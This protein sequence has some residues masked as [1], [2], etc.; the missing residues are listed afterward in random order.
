MN[1][2]FFVIGL[3][4]KKTDLDHRSRFAFNHEECVGT[5]KSHAGQYFILSTCNR[6][7]VYGFAN[8]TNELKRLFQEKAKFIADELYTKV[9]DDAVAHFFKVAAGLDSQIPGDYEIIAQIKAAF[10]LAKAQGRVNGFM[11]KMFNF[12]LQASKEVKNMTSFSD[13]TISVAWCVASQVAKQD[14]V[15]EITVLGAGDTGE[16]VIRYVQKLRPD[17]QINV[18]N[19]DITKLY[20]VASKY[21]VLPFPIAA[22]HDAL[23]DSDALIVTTNS[24]H[25]LVEIQHLSDTPLKSIYDLSVPRNVDPAVYDLKT[26]NVFDVDIISGQINE[27]IENRLREIPKVEAIIMRHIDEFKTWSHRRQL[28]L[29]V[30]TENIQKNAPAF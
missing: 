22:L 26:L 21:D 14:G 2:R 12:A 30:S 28:Y 4:Y 17:M 5:Y 8:D 25:P 11:E 10:L 23:I 27:T 29:A 7:E 6:T 24:P 19:R 15:N 13:G 1:S 18:V 20:L 16:L 9:D 3:S